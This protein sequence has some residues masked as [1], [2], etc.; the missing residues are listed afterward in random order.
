MIP[1]SFSVHISLRNRPA[2]LTGFCFGAALLCLIG[3]CKKE[4]EPKPKPPKKAAAA[5]RAVQERR[6]LNK[7]EEVMRGLAT[8]PPDGAPASAESSSS[9]AARAAR[10]LEKLKTV[11][12]GDLPE[13]L[14]ASWQEMTV[15]LSEVAAAPHA[16][17]SGSLLQR[18]TAA[19]G[20]LND[21]LAKEGLTDF[22]F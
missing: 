20:A 7:V 5:S 11:P 8:P 14:Q 15:V 12:V 16:A 17:V 13:S 4:S 2:W 9:P 19:A 21:A 3:G 10:M 22:R 1:D 6:A 18:G